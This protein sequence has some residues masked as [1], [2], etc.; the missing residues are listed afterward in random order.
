MNSYVVSFLDRTYIHLV[1]RFTVQ[2]HSL[3]D[4]ND[5]GIALYNATPNADYISCKDCLIVIDEV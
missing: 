5:K 1:A 3:Q 2:A 4:A